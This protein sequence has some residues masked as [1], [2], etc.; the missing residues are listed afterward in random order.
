M[1]HWRGEHNL[2]AVMP[3]INSIPG[4]SG[5]FA[6]G[7]SLPGG[8]HPTVGYMVLFVVGELFAYHF[9]SKHLNIS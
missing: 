6:P 3:N 8:W 9:L 7:E 1:A 4:M 5:Q 2:G